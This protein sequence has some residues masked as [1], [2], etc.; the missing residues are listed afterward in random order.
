[1]NFI[2]SILDGTIGASGTF[3]VIGAIGLVLL[4]LSSI[5]DGIFDGF[6]IGDGPI[7]MLSISAFM[8]MFGFAAFISMQAGLSMSSSVVIGCLVGLA[9]GVIAYF[10]MNFFKKSEST[11]S[12]SSNSIVGQE[13]TV[14]TE[15]RP[16]YTGEISVN[17]SG[18]N[19]YFA[20]I[21]DSEEPIK[22]GSKVLIETFMGSNRVKVSPVANTVAPQKEAER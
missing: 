17:S 4:I 2:E 6:H 19:N 11:S 20:A 21:S 22:A 14:S 1:M 18:M 8:A 7:S 16:G 9:S 3:F 15:I 13:G 5:L 10:M 12:F